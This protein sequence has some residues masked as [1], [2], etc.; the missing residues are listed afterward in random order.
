MFR[1]VLRVIL[2]NRNFKSHQFGNVVSALIVSYQKELSRECI[3]RWLRPYK[4]VLIDARKARTTTAAYSSLEKSPKTGQR[5][6]A[7]T[8]SFLF[9]SLF[10]IRQRALLSFIQHC[11]NYGSQTNKKKF[12]FS[13]IDTWTSVLT[14]T[15]F[16]WFRQCK[17]IDSRPKAHFRTFNT[18]TVWVLYLLI[19]GKA[20]N[21]PGIFIIPSTAVQSK[22]LY[23][24][25]VRVKSITII[26]FTPSYLIYYHTHYFVKY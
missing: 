2:K 19:F 16:K 4:S 23:T 25:V 24:I 10:A 7:S 3:Q 1:L 9:L 26:T 5:G 15:K 6:L 12:L 18:R 17:V 11:K 21:G 22:V 20:P 8:R 13:S 14:N